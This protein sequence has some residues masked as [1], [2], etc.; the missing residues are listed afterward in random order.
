VDRSPVAI[1]Q[2]PAST[3]GRR[4][5]LRTLCVL[6]A[7]LFAAHLHAQELLSP[8][9]AFVQAGTAKQTHQVTTGLLWDWERRWAL[10][11]GEVSGYWELSVSGWSYP[12]PN[13][14]KDAWLGQVGVVPTFRY[15]PDAGRASWFLELG[16]GVTAMTTLY[17]TQ[18]KR[19]STSFNFADHVAV[20][21]TFDA[22]RRHELALR[23]Q[24]FSNAGIKQPNPG[25]NFWEIRYVHRF[26]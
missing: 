9:A 1:E 8:S 12:T 16:V 2:G 17:E 7:Q 24:H 5:G 19:F 14:R 26:H 11:G 10:G 6:I 18:R 3:Q 13:G 23:L 4:V 21:I 25:E 22:P 20:G 15:V